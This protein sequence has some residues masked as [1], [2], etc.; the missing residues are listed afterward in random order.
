MNLLKDIQTVG[1]VG[2]G[3]LGTLYAWELTMALGQ[4]RVLVLADRDRTERYRREGIWFNG[5]KYRFHFADAATETQPVDLLLFATKFTGL[6]AA[7]ETCRHLVG[8]ETT[9]VSVLNGISSEQ[10]LGEAFSPEQVV[11][12]VAEKMSAKKEGNHVLVHPLGR[13]A[14]GVPEGQPTDHLDRLCAFFDRTLFP[15]HRNP[16][17]RTHM[18][19]KLLCNT[20]ANQAA[21]VHQCGYCGLQTPGPARD[22]MLGAMREVVLVANAEGIPLSEADVEHWTAII[23]TFPGEGEP[24]MRQDGKAHRR[25]EVE[26]FSGTIRRLARKHGIPVPVNDRLYEKIRLMEQNLK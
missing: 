7:M 13:L 12:C 10:L 17:I 6:E 18:W 22:T 11:W 3:A 5:T 15:Y 25:S 21:M 23:D 8:P 2:L 4:D 9:L 20:G 16:D 19:S 14:V 26:L 24:S 1:I